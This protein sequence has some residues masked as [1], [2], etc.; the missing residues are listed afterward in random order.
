MRGVAILLVL[1]SHLEMPSV[2]GPQGAEW[3]ARLGDFGVKIFFVLSGFLITALLVGEHRRNGRIAVGRF[4]LRRAF[5]IFPAAYVFILAIIA[6]AALGWLHLPSADT[7][8][9]LTYTMNFN[10]T[11]GWWLGHTWSLSVEEQFYLAWPLALVLAR[12]LGGAYVAAGTVLVAPLAR[13]IVVLWFPGLEEGIERAFMSA[14][15]GFAVGGFLAIVRQQLERHEAYMRCLRAWWVPLLVLLAAVVNQ[16][17][18]HPLIFFVLLQPLVYLA[19]ALGLHRWQVMPHDPIGRLLNW[20]PL[21]FVG[22]ISY[23]LYLWQQ[24]F[25]FPAGHGLVHR[26]PLDLL[27]SFTLAWASYRLIERPSLRLRDRWWPSRAALAR[28]AAEP[29]AA[30]AV[31]GASV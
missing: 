5:R 28:G 26:F 12:P 10:T 22:S 13:G 15:D 2:V 19:L 23:S 18:H 27:L 4:Y 20:A 9:A 24:P 3:I 7:I 31:P 29:G 30:G 17:E 11:P 16:L 14:A 8:F 21:A 25:L 1:L 6:A